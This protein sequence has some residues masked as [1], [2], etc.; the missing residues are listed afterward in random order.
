MITKVFSAALWGLDAHKI[1]VEVDLAQG[2]PG[3]HIIGLA[4][5]AVQESRE[6]IRSALRNCKI[7]FPYSKKL[8]INLAPADIKKTGP[9]FDLAIVVGILTAM[10][11]VKKNFKNAL[12]VGE[13]SLDGSLRRVNGVLSIAHF[14]RDSG[15]KEI[16]VPFYNANEAALVEGI[17][18]IPL[19]S[20]QEFLNVINGEKKRA[21]INPKENKKQAPSY[22]DISS[23]RGQVHA[24]RALEIAA[25]GGH[26]LLFNGPPGSGKTMLA[27]AIPGILPALAQEESLEVTKIYSIAGLL[28]PDEYVITARPFRAPHHTS[29]YVALVGGGV[30][31]RPGEITLAHRGVLFLDEF[32]EFSRKVLEC[33]RQPLEDKEITISRAAYGACFPASFMLVASKNPCPCGFLTHPEKECRCMPSAI[34]RYTQKLSG[35]IL[36]R[37]DLHVE[38]GPVDIEILSSSSP[39][40]ERSLDVRARVEHAREVQSKRFK[41]NSILYNAEMKTDDISEYCV[42][43]AE[44]E[45]FLKNAAQKLEL[46]ARA[47]FKVIKV[48]QTISDLEKQECIYKNHIAEALQYRF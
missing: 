16:Y 48:A 40:S 38:V 9:S 13:L 17:E 10:G 18:I 32:S 31:P 11:E 36:D 4:D 5:I 28:K 39:C 2:F 46:S 23:I 43:N 47:Y 33:L 41:K 7:T 27:Q 26:N 30:I 15:F 37:F 8:V 14:A 6:R 35:P 34:S 44:T 25:S 21:I 12:F 22:I 29:S 24:K 19:E 42:M 45:A 20:L 1:E 3:F